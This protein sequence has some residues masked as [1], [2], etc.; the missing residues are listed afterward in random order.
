MVNCV[1]GDQHQPDSSETERLNM[2]RSARQ[3][4]ERHARIDKCGLAITLAEKVSC[5][6]LVD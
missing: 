4:L 5:G 1:F 2:I 6:A 3:L